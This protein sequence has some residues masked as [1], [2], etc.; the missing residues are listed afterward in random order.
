MSINYDAIR[1]R[2]AAVTL[3]NTTGALGTLNILRAPPKS[4][5]TRRIDKVG[6]TDMITKQIS[7]SGSR[8]CEAIRAYPR[9]VDPMVSVSYSNASNNAGQNNMGYGSSGQRSIQVK[10][11]YPP[12]SLGA[13]GMQ[14][15][16]PLR[17][18][19]DLMPLSR[20]ARL[21]TDAFTQPGFADYSKRIVCETSPCNSKAVKD[22]ILKTRIQTS[23]VMQYERPV[24]EGYEVKNMVN[25]DP[26]HYAANS[27][28]RSMDIAKKA[29]SF[30]VTYD[31][32]EN[33][34]HAFAQAQINDPTQSKSGGDG[35][36]NFST[37]KYVVDFV[38][39]SNVSATKSLHKST[40]ADQMRPVGS[41]EKYLR[42]HDHNASVNAG[43]SGQTMDQDPHNDRSVYLRETTPSV[44]ANASL[45]RPDY[46]L[47]APRPEKELQLQRNLPL[48]AMKTNVASA[49]G[50]NHNNNTREYKLAPTLNKGAYTTRGTVSMSIDQDQHAR[51]DSIPFSKG[52][53]NNSI[54]SNRK[55]T[56]EARMKSQQY[57]SDSIHNTNVQPPL[58]FAF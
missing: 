14:F 43:F 31:I 19:E 44:F 40:T 54:L 38:P 8:I 15:R 27:G 45:S 9:G 17:R 11:A 42:S 33:P 26:L 47:V 29:S 6:D 21:P 5:M 52:V 39:H 23:K 2:R 10:N 1:N 32:N 4:V 22:E 25:Q 12:Y 7:N 50:S 34:L 36:D 58:T 55:I 48:T 13:L 37:R 24:K 49:I 16:P 20:Q 41:T 30:D 46:H 28:M 18:Q 3:P 56:Q 53:A 35:R 51:E 57:R